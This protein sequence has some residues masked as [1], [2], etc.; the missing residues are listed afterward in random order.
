M[1]SLNV[2][3]YITECMNS[4]VHQT[5]KDIE[6]ICVDAGSE[7]GT[8][9]ILKEFAANDSRIRLIQSDKKSYG[10][11]MNLGLD[12]AQGDYI[13]IVETDD[14][15]ELNMFEVLYNVAKENCVDF[16][17]SNYYWYYTKPEKID[18]QFENLYRGPYNQ[19]FCPKDEVQV[20]GVTP[21]IWSGIYN[22]EFLIKNNIRF[23]ET[24][25][26]SYQDTSFF[27]MV[28]TAA[29]RTY[30]LNEYYLHYRR[31]NENSSVASVGKVFCVSDEMYY[32]EKFLSSRPEDNNRLIHPYMKEKF[33]K[34]EWNYNRLAPEFQWSFLKLMFK[35][36]SAHNNS[37]LILD[38]VFAD[39]A[40]K[41][42]LD[43]LIDNPFRYFQETCKKYSTRPYSD[44]L[45]SAEVLRESRI[46]R[47]LVS[48]II[49]A[50]NAQKTITKCI[51]SV[52][53]QTLKNIEII[54][55]DDGSEDQTL[56]DLLWHADEDDR[57]TVLHQINQGQSAARNAA[58]KKAKGKYIQFLD[59]DDSLRCDAVE[60]LF[61]KAEELE[62]E[63]LCFDGESIYETEDLRKRFPYYIDAYE[64]ISEELIPDV[65]TGKEYF[66]I[67]K[68]EKKYRVSPCMVLFKHE[69]LTKHNI[70]FIH[71]II[72]EDNAF[73]FAC[74]MNAERV[75][76]IEDKLYQRL[77]RNGSTVTQKKTW[78]HVY[79]FLSCLLEMESIKY[80]M[81]YDSELEEN[82][83][84]EFA[85]LTDSIRYTYRLTSDKQLCESK[86]CS[87]EWA[88]LNEIINAESKAPVVKKDNKEVKKIKNSKSY[89]LGRKITWLPRKIRGGYRCLKKYGLQYTYRKLIGMDPEW[90]KR[91]PYP[92]FVS[93][94]AYKMSGAFLSEVALNRILNKEMHVKSHVILPYYG[95]GV[96]I[97]KNAG[98]KYQVV[99]SNDWITSVGV[100]QDKLFRQKKYLEHTENLRA[101]RKIAQI[102]LKKD[103]NIIHS[104]TTYTY[105]GALASKITGLPH[106]WHLREFLE[107]DQ[108]NEIYCKQYGYSLL[109]RANRII[110]ISNSLEKKY[111]SI[112]NPEK[113]KTIYNGLDTRIYYHP[114]KTIFETEKPILL[115]VSGS[116]SPFK[117]REDLINACKLLQDSGID[118]DLWFVGWCGTELQDLVKKAGLYEKTKFFG[119]Q[120]DTSV[121]FSKADIFF[122]C[123]KFEA[124]GR[125]TVEAMLNGCL[126][127]GAKSAG[128]EEL[129]E[130]HKSGLLY[131][132][133]DYNQLFDCIAEALSNKEVMRAIADY[134]RMVMYQTMSAERNAEE[135]FDTYCSVLSE[136]A[137]IGRVRKLLAKARIFWLRGRCY[138]RKHIAGPT[139]EKKIALAERDSAGAI[140]T[141]AVASDVGK[142][143]VSVVV[144]IYNVKQYLSQCL[145][146][147]CA[148]SMHEIEIICV[149]D[150]S[151]D[152]SDDIIRSF[153]EKDSRIVMIDKANSGY[154]NSV[155]LGIDAA[156]GEYVAIVES[157]DFI[158]KN[159]YRDLYFL[160]IE[161]GTVDIIKSGYWQYYDTEDGKGKRIPAPINGTLKPPIAVFNVYDYPEIV[162]HHPSIWSC[163]YRK[164]FL[165]SN[166]IRFLEA[167]GAGWVDNPF[168]METFCKAERVTWTATPYYHWRMTNQGSSSFVKDCSM[169]FERTKEMF[170]FLKEN[171][172]N[173]SALFESVYKRVL[174]N[175]ASTLDNPNYMPEKDDHLIISQLEEIDPEYLLDQRVQV[176][177]RLAYTY[178]MKKIKLGSVNDEYCSYPVRN[179][180]LINHKD[181][182]ESPLVSII[183]PIYNGEKNIYDTLANVLNQTLEEIE[184]ICVNDGS[185]DNTGIILN[186]ISQIDKR[187]KVFEQSNSG[188]AIARNKAIEMA[189]GHYISFMDVDDQYPEESTLEKL[190][191][192]GV[193]HNAKICG[194][195]ML[196]LKVNGEEVKD[197]R[198]HMS[199]QTLR[200]EGMISY[201]DYQYEYGYQRFLYERALLIDND[202]RFPNYL[203]FQDPP[204]M[205][206]AMLAAGE[207]Y[208]TTDLTYAYT[209]NIGVRWNVQKICDLIAGLTDLLVISSEYKLS[210]LHNMAIYRFNKEY[211][212]VIIEYI[213]E[214]NVQNLI[215]LANEKIDK[216]LLEKGVEPVLKLVSDISIYYMQ[217]RFD[218]I[219]Y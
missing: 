90:E 113:V 19:V 26:A 96:P 110:T 32:F 109:G 94:D 185:T 3:K 187:V 29:E 174:W 108:G 53:N 121:Y 204:F 9:E 111:S 38:R 66:C 186:E 114:E 201:K 85:L 130:D 15:A 217:T 43:T 141:N 112:V 192:L 11:Q 87:L 142:I 148:Q 92:L 166:N 168:L 23:N 177:E 103:C 13:G 5:L 138:Y 80:Q 27:F 179:Y 133:G 199:K 197:F 196:S 171:G 49:P 64:F 188:S 17:K 136:T 172:I 124:F 39:K 73:S 44:E 86:L 176:S 140:E 12:V 194:G 99:P 46:Q 115:F 216:R 128:T 147:I 191:F 70:T 107:E 101:A 154:G 152:G 45:L 35:E 74:F 28:C 63:L 89:K 151:T 59:S 146:S 182:V 24:A 105:V 71:G 81:D 123:S 52:R 126:V 97:I 189:Q 175:A 183:I 165:D 40:E 218:S 1:P 129:V 214:K 120:E 2:A 118:F 77:V 62:L 202:I 91:K 30:F 6:I 55:V 31:D 88:R 159:M 155:N 72:H 79:G 145:E 160:A 7:D 213:K 181:A 170:A 54:C 144:P 164:E 4:V 36:F 198:G 169:P 51:S 137:P 200:R 156:K 195:S 98:V 119:Y 135:I 106:V 122:M 104:N 178:F 139:I 75:W 157:D 215:L 211:Y 41:K 58:L 8:F 56:S 193:R 149:N 60:I 150:G 153:A 212:S 33:A 95:S 82:V 34:Y 42:R 83:S 184:V 205:V 190:Y 206:R 203:R 163:L 48:I 210:E 207:F 117:G 116:D 68:S 50:Y 61:K 22:R 102:A 132:Y 167:K 173:D 161:R 65:V 21:S 14:W 180:S 67:S 69:F 57:I 93:S 20:F 16:I 78:K 10:Y 127:I 208:A 158:D 84:D 47:P 131:Q 162:F 76:H 143:K 18:K 37:K 219:C 134:A 25:G 100:E 125:T 209:Q